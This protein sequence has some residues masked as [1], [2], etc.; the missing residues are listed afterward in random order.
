MIRPVLSPREKTPARRNAPGAPAFRGG[1]PGLLGRASGRGRGAS[2]QG[3]FRDV[4]G[5]FR[6]P[7]RHLGGGGQDDPPAAVRAGRVLGLYHESVE[8]RGRGPAPCRGH[9]GHLA[10]PDL[11]RTSRPGPDPVDDALRHDRRAAVGPWARP[12][13]KAKL[14]VNEIITTLM[15]NYVAIFLLDFFFVR[16]LERPG[17]LRVPHVAP[18]RRFGRAAH[19]G[20]PPGST[21]VLAFGLA[22][23]LLSALL[24]GRT[25]LGFGHAGHR[26]QPGG[27]QD[28][29][30]CPWPGS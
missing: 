24:L 13:L 5:H 17:Q 7:L 22:A 6:R 18:V 4:P 23:A 15:L 9:R 10:G 8:H 28:Q 14:Q 20:A 3:F 16:P 11:S 12:L 21:W 26:G 2:A 25:K 30:Q 27:G 29:R 1:G 19:P